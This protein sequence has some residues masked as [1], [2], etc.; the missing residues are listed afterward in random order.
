MKP[1][2]VK[3]NSFSLYLAVVDLFLRTMNYDTTTSASKNKIEV[4]CMAALL[5]VVETIIPPLHFFSPLLAGYEIRRV[6]DASVVLLWFRLRAAAAI[7]REQ[8]D[9]SRQI[10]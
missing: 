9:C 6:G 8:G 3:T 1:R 10:F 2:E 4:P 7:S 5:T